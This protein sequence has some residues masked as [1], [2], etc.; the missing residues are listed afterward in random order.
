MT[1]QPGFRLP[2]EVADE[3]ESPG[4]GHSVEDT[5]GHFRQSPNA[6]AERAE[7]DDTEGYWRLVGGADSERAEGDDTEGHHF[8]RLADAEKTEGNDVE[9]HSSKHR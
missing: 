8:G 7:G 4:I 5:E 2:P 6:D 9:G 3:P 1:D